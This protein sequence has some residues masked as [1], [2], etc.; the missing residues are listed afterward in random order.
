MEQYDHV[1][2]ER[3]LEPLRSLGSRSFT[4]DRNQFTFYFY[5]TKPGE[6]NK[7]PEQSDFVYFQTSRKGE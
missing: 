5:V 1:L 7:S 6:I 4:H 3:N 2:L